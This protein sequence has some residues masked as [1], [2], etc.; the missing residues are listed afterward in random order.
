MNKGWAA[1]M[2]PPITA[3]PSDKRERLR[4]RIARDRAK[5][6]KGLARGTLVTR[7]VTI[8]DIDDDFR[9]RRG[10]RR[11]ARALRVDAAHRTDARAFLGFARRIENVAQ[12][13][14]LAAVGIVADQ[15]AAVDDDSAAKSRTQGDADEVA[16]TLRI[17][18]F[19]QEGV[20][21]GEKSRDGFAVDEQ[22][23]VVID[24]HRQ[25]ELRF[26][27]R[28]E[29]HAARPTERGENSANAPR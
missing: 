22:V 16:I 24:E 11:D 23:A 17:V 19:R 21:M 28:P 13:M 4:Q 2:P 5:L 20:H 18:C 25:F 6:A 8:G 1:E 15:Q 9:L 3:N 7:C 27:H 14:R 12:K 26:Q 10:V 29:R